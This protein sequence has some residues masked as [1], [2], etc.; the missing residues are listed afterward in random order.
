VAAKSRCVPIVNYLTEESLAL[1]RA[2]RHERGRVA[3]VIKII[4]T[5]ELAAV[6]LPKPL[7]RV[8]EALLLGAAETIKWHIPQEA[9]QEVGRG[10]ASAS[11]GTCRYRCQGSWLAAA[12]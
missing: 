5:T 9:F 4:G 10:K 3:K 8:A 11:D 12:T 6:C 7:E 2:P 1:L